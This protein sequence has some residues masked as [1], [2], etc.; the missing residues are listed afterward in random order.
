M[1]V[2]DKGRPLMA[3]RGK[4]RD[5]RER[6]LRKRERLWKVQSTTPSQGD[7]NKQPIRKVYRKGL[8]FI[9]SMCTPSKRLSRGQRPRSLHAGKQAAG[10][11]H[12]PGGEKERR[13][14][15]GLARTRLPL[16]WEGEERRQHL[17]R[18][19]S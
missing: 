2:D 1:S 19:G 3:G 13:S 5:F 12:S 17:G 15:Q 7:R 4:L 14:E 6:Q 11:S 18:G 16:E 9:M 10:L 8:F